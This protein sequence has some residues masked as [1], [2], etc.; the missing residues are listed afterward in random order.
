MN[1]SVDRT[2]I[3][4]VANEE[5]HFGGVKANDNISFK[6]DEN[7]ILGIIGP[8]GSGKTTLFNVITSVYPADKGTIRF[9]GEI[10]NRLPSFKITRKGI[11]RT[12]QTTKVWSRMP[13]IWNL[14][15]SQ[16]CGPNWKQGSCEE[17]AMKILEATHLTEYAQMPPLSIPW[18]AQRR[19]MIANALATEADL[20]LLDEPTAGMSM[21]ESL[22]LVNIVKQLN[23]EL[24]KTILII[25]HNMKVVMNIS[26]RIVA[27]NFGKKIA[28]GSPREI[29]QDT[30]VVEAYLGKGDIYAR[31]K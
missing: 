14:L 1:S 23:D 27:L 18:A 7:E 21:E 31:D 20:L 30:E 29:S 10:I 13:V 22:E 3:L 8:N 24:G 26:D 25:E 15:T 19:L 4:D 11:A 28:E 16:L 2:A 12:F 17:K 6:I 9:K 5:K